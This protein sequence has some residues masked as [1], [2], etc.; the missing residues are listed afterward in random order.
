MKEIIIILMIFVFSLSVGFFIEKYKP[1]EIISYADK[2]WSLGNIYYKLGFELE[3]ESKPDYKYIINGKRIHKSRFRKSKLNTNLT[4]S[5]QMKKNEINR[6]WDCGKMKF[7][8]IIVT[9]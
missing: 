3:S 6:I 2:N 1:S 7:R 4:E 8:K 9:I 5:M